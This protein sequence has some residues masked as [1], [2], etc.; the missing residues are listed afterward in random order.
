M[1]ASAK[2]STR[3]KLSN[4]RLLSAGLVLIGIMW[5][6][7]TKEEDQLSET[8]TFV[9]SSPEIGQDS[10]LPAEYTC[11][12]SSASLPLNWSGFPEATKSFALIMHHEASPTD[13]HWYWVL[14]NIPV[15]VNSLPK[16][17]TGTGT[18]GNNSV[19]GQTRY[20]PPCSQG[21][22]AKKYIITLYA[23][24][25]PVSLNVPD[26]AVSRAVLLEGIKKITLASASLTVSYSRDI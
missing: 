18:A 22:G 17:A 5:T 6:A 13:I 3:I 16:N 14:Y 9:L 20:A 24:T 21:P 23:L 26:S 11:D 1:K 10:L 25:E 12:G 8:S 7:C 15:S 2:S 19:N 4:L